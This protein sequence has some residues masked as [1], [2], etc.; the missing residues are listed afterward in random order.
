MR[1]VAVAVTAIALLTQVSELRAQ[2][3]N[4]TISSE[5]QS[6]FAHVVSAALDQMK[7]KWTIKSATLKGA[8]L[9]LD[10]FEFLTVDNDGFTLNV[11]KR[12]TR[13]E[14][15]EFKRKS[16]TFVSQCSSPDYPEGLTYEISVS[17]DL[18]K[19][20]YRTDGA[21]IAPDPSANDGQLLVQVWTKSK[22]K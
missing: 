21:H 13:F 4:E 11:Q 16:E 19:I 14:F 15:T 2:T 3:S 18:I 22:T 17:K 12:T 1:C 5:R 10:Q 8:D 7:G 6:G 20:R 9:P